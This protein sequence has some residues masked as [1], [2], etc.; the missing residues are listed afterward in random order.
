[1]KEDFLFLKP[2]KWKL[3]SYISLNERPVGYTIVSAGIRGAA[4][5]HKILVDSDYRGFGIGALLLEDAKAKCRRRKI[6]K[7]RFKVRVQNQSANAFYRKHNVNYLRRE[8]DA[9]G[10]ERYLC[11]LR[12]QE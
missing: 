1:M 7:L 9:D 10:V 12:L 2:N 6:K 3:S 8:E 5:L 11:E 4:Y